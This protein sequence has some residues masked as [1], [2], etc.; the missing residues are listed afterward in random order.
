MFLKKN[1]G[2]LVIELYMIC[3]LY[4]SLALLWL[5]GDATTMVNAKGG[6]AFGVFTILHIV[7]SIAAT[8][9]T[10]LSGS[11]VIPMTADCADYEVYRSGRYVPGLMGT[12]FSFVDKLISSLAPLIAG[13]LFAMVGFKDTL[14]DV[15]DVYK[16]QLYTGSNII[17]SFTCIQSHRHNFPNQLFF[18]RKMYK[19]I[20]AESSSNKRRIMV[21]D[22][23]YKNLSLIHI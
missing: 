20:V 9:F 21:I 14:P 19:D 3:L 1:L 18:S 11:I 22:C 13:L 8:G 6:L 5:F 2:N 12:L 23:L 15:K 17:K 16:R 10:G 4:T 7:L